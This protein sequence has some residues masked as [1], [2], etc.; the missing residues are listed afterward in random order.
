MAQAHDVIDK[1]L[2]RSQ[3]IDDTV[4]LFSQCLTSLLWSIKLNTIERSK[5]VEL[6]PSLGLGSFGLHCP[7]PA[8]A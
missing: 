8:Q 3:P 1:K 2:F 7:L 4:L 6:S 5:E